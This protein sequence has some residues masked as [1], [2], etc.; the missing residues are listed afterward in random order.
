[1]LRRIFG[2]KR[3]EVTGKWRR[4]QKEE[5]NELYS[6]PIVVRVIKSRRIR[7]AGI[8]TYGGKRGAY[9]ILMR[10]LQGKRPIGKP[11]VNGRRILKW[12]FEKWDGGMD[13]INVAHNRDRWRALVNVVMN[14]QVP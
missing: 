7:W 12:I 14:L 8:R 3:D 11:Q 5:L 1:M 4:L 13:W 2:S 6:S 9:D 10:K